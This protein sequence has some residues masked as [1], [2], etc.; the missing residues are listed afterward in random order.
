MEYLFNSFTLSPEKFELR[1]QG[2]RVH[3]EPQV[4]LLLKLLIENRDRMILK[5]E[6]INEIWDGRVIS[7]ASVASRIKLARIAVGDDGSAQHTIRTIYGQGFRFTA[8]VTTQANPTTATAKVITSDKPS[9]KPARYTK[10]S[11]AVLPFQSLGAT[12]AGA[13]L[14]DAVPH[15]L[16]Q[17]FSRLRWLFVIARGSAFHFRALYPDVKDIGKTLNVRYVLSGSVDIQGQSL[18]ITVELSDTT[19]GGVVWGK[20][21]RQTSMQYIR[22]ET[23]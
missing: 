9:E 10:P 5:D 18:T 21:L 12:G 3:L 22:S 23:K 19:N 17:A 20:G 13:A 11:I 8:E 15:D 14:S 6:I 1:T 7:D 16:I 2:D 4:F